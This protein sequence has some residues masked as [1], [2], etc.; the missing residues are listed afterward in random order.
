MTNDPFDNISFSA[1]DAGTVNQQDYIDLIHDPDILYYYIKDARNKAQTDL[2]IDPGEK[3]EHVNI[4]SNIEVF[5]SAIQY[6]EAFGIYLVAYIKNRDELIEHLTKTRPGQVEDFF[7]AIRE[8]EINSWLSENDISKEINTILREIYGYIHTDP[9]SVTRD[10]EPVT[11]DELEEAIE[12][13][14]SAIKSDITYIGEFYSQFHPIYNAVKHGNRAIPSEQNNFDITPTD[15]GESI[16]LEGDVQYVT[17]LCRTREG[18]PYL[19]GLPLDFLL[20]HTLNIVERVHRLFTQLKTVSEA[21]ITDS[22]FDIP[23]YKPTSGEARDEHDTPDWVTMRHASGINI[24][25]ATPELVEY[26]SGPLQRTTAARLE[27]TS[28]GIDVHTTTSDTITDDY[29]IS[30][31]LTEQGNE[32]LIPQSVLN[33]EVSFT[34]NNLDAEQYYELL[35]FEDRIEANDVSSLTVISDDTGLEYDTHEF[36]DFPQLDLEE[37]LPREEIEQIALL[38][39]ITQQQILAPLDLND[40]QRTVVQSL[41]DDNPTREEAV[42]TVEKLEELGK[43]RDITVVQAERQAADGEVLEEERIFAVEGT[44]GITLTDDETGDTWDSTETGLEI[45]LAITGKTYEDVVSELSEGFDV[46]EDYVEQIPNGDEHPPELGMKLKT[47]ILEDNFWGTTHELTFQVL[48]P[49]E[50]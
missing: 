18:T 38:Q 43:A 49:R 10:G 42:E 1:L 25:P 12:N 16:T 27:T 19:T 44:F 40:E 4:H 28:S 30:V 35:K 41:L 21:N 9:D 33:F 31:T 7:D 11:G 26:Q 13:S 5:Q 45:P 34:L 29:P 6:V 14:V 2:T 46:I 8:D 37:F 23:F 15:G 47:G 32:G 17:F 3:R 22:T 48:D 39:T 20:E 50:P 36:E 24:L